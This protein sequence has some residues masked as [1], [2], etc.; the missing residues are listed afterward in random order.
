MIF[1]YIAQYVEKLRHDFR[2]SFESIFKL[3]LTKEY[4]HNFKTM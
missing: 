3:N 2:N 1:F 4:D